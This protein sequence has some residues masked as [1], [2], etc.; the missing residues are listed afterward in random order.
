MVFEVYNPASA[1][2]IY[3]LDK[4]EKG[5]AYCLYIKT[6]LT[7][8]KKAFDTIVHDILFDERQQNGFLSHTN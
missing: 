4:V 6:I 2:L 7:N 8:L 5:L 1:F 3:P